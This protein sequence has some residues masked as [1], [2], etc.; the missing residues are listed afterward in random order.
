MH[1]EGRDYMPIYLTKEE[2]DLYKKEI[3]EGKSVLSG[4][5]D[6]CFKA[7]MHHCR[8]YLCMIISEI[9]GAS[10]DEVLK[11]LKILPNEYASIQKKE[12]RRVS[13]FVV[14]IGDHH[15][16]LEM[17][18]GKYY[19]SLAEKNLAYA[20]KLLE[21]TIMSGSEIRKGTEVIE[22]NFDYMKIPFI[23]EDELSV[24]EFR[25]Q[26]KSKGYLHPYSP[27]II[28]IDLF[29][30][31]KKYYNKREINALEKLMLMLVL[32]N[33]KDLEKVSGGDPKLKKVE[34][35]LE[36]LSSEEFITEAEREMWE[37]RK[38]QDFR[39]EGFEEGESKGIQKTQKE[40]VLNMLKNNLD[41]E[42]IM[43]Y[44]G[45]TLEEVQKIQEEKN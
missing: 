33:K 4:T 43:K 25:M 9:T 29:K 16:I 2:Q 35:E 31:E 20:Y 30:I 21:Q 22:I 23:K 6:V 44:T 27:K 40:I 36:T 19:D 14:T 39:L 38:Y 8:E 28:Y 42:T 15:L 17:N 32:T 11:E 13:D 41:I 34:E 3:K 45:L 7:I 12:K 5:F 18:R 10:Y 1:F 26:E 37:R 24:H